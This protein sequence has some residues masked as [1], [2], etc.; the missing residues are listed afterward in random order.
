MTRHA[1]QHAS[2]LPWVARVHTLERHAAL[3]PNGA[4]WPARGS[5]R[6]EAGAGAA[7]LAVWAASW[8]YLVAAVAA[9]AGR[10][11]AESV[12]AGSV[13]AGSVHPDRAGH[14]GALARATP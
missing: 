1:A 4:G 6:R 14:Q 12:H 13:H 2:P 10:L 7:L 11:H 5:W 9:P 3:P 8:I